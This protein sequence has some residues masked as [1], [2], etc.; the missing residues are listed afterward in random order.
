M[1]K[2]N[3]I[4]ILKKA[5]KS[6]TLTT[7]DSI[8]ADDVDG[9]DDKQDVKAHFIIVVYTSISRRIVADNMIA[10]LEKKRNRYIKW[11]Q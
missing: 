7:A 2:R 9:D 10:S 5:T 4:I 3:E 11:E 8:C 6:A 1:P